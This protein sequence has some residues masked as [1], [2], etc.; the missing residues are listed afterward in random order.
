[1]KRYVWDNPALKK[2][3]NTLFSLT[4]VLMVVV[5]AC[6]FLLPGNLKAV[7]LIILVCAIIMW[8]ASYRIQ[9]QDKALKLMKGKKSEPAK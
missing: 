7:N 2:K 5:L 3:Y 4:V 9:A 6:L 8:F 1:M